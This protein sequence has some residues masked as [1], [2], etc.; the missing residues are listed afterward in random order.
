MGHKCDSSRLHKYPDYKVKL[1]KDYCTLTLL[2]CMDYLV[3]VALP[4]NPEGIT[5]GHCEG[6]AKKNASLTFSMENGSLG[7]PESG[8]VCHKFRLK[9]NLKI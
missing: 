6:Q 2:G 7:C 9:Q 8:E 4:C 5:A 1:S 3:L